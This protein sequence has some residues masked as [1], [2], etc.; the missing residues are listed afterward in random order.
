MGLTVITALR[1]DSPEENAQWVDEL[2]LSFPVLYDA[3]EIA[4]DAWRTG[5]GRPQYIV[6]DQNL[7]RVGEGQGRD[8]HEEMEALALDTL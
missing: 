4:W 8:G 2:G 5:V 6:I 7:E 1:A 3:D